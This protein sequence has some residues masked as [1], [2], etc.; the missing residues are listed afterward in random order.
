MNAGKF[1]A[2]WTHRCRFATRRRYKVTTT[3][4]RRRTEDGNS[5]VPGAGI[6]PAFWVMRRSPPPCS[7]HS[8][9]NSS[10]ISS[11]RITK[12]CG[13]PLPG[14][15]LPQRQLSPCD[16]ARRPHDRWI[17]AL[18]VWHWLWSALA[19]H[20]AFFTRINPAAWLFA[21]L[22]LGQAV[23]LFRLG[24]VQRRLSFAPWGS[25][26][27]PLAWGLI[28]YTLAYP[29]INAIDHL[30]LSRNPTLAFHARRRSLRPAC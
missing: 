3:T 6:R 10:S 26:W 19:Y 22:F 27:A 11:P 12:R 23:R 20:V 5:H 14:C 15:G 8:R 24:V 21:I 7:C 18:L 16:S 13:R 28:A 4:R 2:S 17:T 1:G 9:E 25:A 30:S 29:A